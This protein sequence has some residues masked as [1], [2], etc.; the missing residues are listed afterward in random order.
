MHTAHVRFTSD[1]VTPAA[2][3]DQWLRYAAAC[4]APDLNDRELW[5]SI[6]TACLYPRCRVVCGTQ[7]TRARFV[8]VQEEKE[9]KEAERVKAAKE[10]ADRVAQ[11][12]KEAAAKAV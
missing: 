3:R 2:G 1:L 6:A 7:R 8:S 10:A 5:L 4:L 9:R 11:Q 12:Q